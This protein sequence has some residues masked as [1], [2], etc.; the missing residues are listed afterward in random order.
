[1]NVRDAVR[2]MMKARRLDQGT[3]A[4]MAGFKRQSNISEMLRGKSHMR[5]DNLIRIANAMGCEIVMKSTRRIDDP[6]TGR[7]YY[8]TFTITLDDNEQTLA[9][10]G[11]EEGDDR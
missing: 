3:V 7:E 6:E 9:D 11:S 8:P 2:A 4:H 10:S 5:V 1:M